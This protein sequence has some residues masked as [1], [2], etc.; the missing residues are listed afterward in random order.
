MSDHELLAQIRKVLEDSPFVGEGHRKVWARLR[1]RG[2]CTSRKRVLRLTR[3]AGLLAPTARARKRAA[4]LHEGTIT[5]AVPDSLWAT[6]ATEGHTRQQGRCAVFAIIDHASGEAFTDVSERMDRFA[7][8]DLL[9]EVCTERFGSVEAAVCSGLS[10]R[11]DGGPCFR[12]DHYHAEIDHLGI[13]RSPAHHYEPETNGCVEKFIQTLKEQVLWIARF[14]TASSCAQPCGRS[15]APTTPTGCSSATTIAPRSRPA[16]ICSPSKR[17]TDHSRQ[18]PRGRQIAAQR[19]ALKA[20]DP[21]RARSGMI[22]LSTKVS[23]ELGAV[24]AGAT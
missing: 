12:S 18:L 21:D 17:M 4:R 13:A 19:L 7:A 16:S 15:P 10:L 20:V 22:T 6:D 1:R 11:Y 24:H 2:V 8:A 14:D 5:V 23:G 3:E 9:R